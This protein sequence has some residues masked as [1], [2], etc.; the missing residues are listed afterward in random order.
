MKRLRISIP[1]YGAEAEAVLL[2]DIAPQTCGAIWQTLK[3]PLTV[4]G[5]HAAWVGPEVFIN[6][7]SDQRTFDGADLP[8]ENQTCFPLPGDLVWLWF[9]AGAWSGLT[10]DLYEI[11]VIYAPNAILFNPAG[12]APATVFGRV[13]SNLD[14]LAAA[15]RRFREDGRVDMTFRRL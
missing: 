10:D 7:P 14:E 11:G 5:L 3:R 1:D 8:K 12:W 6:I 15:C 13:T 9:L 4:R 2:E